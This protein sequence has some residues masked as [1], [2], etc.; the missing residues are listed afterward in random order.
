[1]NLHHQQHLAPL[2][3]CFAFFKRIRRK[4]KAS[5]FAILSQGMST[6]RVLLPPEPRTK[7]RMANYYFLM[8]FFGFGYN[9]ET[10]KK[11]TSTAHSKFPRRN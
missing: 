5:T 6:Q 7:T 10:K 9:S 4:R 3:A 11:N 2:M 1:M 8:L